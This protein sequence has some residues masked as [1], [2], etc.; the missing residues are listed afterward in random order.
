MF[1]EGVMYVRVDE[2]ERLS[3]WDTFVIDDAAM[4]VKKLEPK[5][6]VATVKSD[7]DDG[8]ESEIMTA[9]PKMGSAGGNKHNWVAPPGGGDIDNL[10]FKCHVSLP[11]RLL[12]PTDGAVFPGCLHRTSLTASFSS[13]RKRTTARGG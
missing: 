12:S 13:R 2:S 4:V 5:R 3:L 10:K 7:G 6:L 8:I 1:N 9:A 11:G